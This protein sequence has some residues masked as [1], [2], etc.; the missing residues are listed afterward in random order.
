MRRPE[1][2]PRWHELLAV[3]SPESIRSRFQYLFKAT[4]HEMTTRYCFIDYD[5]EMAIVAELQGPDGQRSLAGV[6]RLASDAD[7]ERAEYAIL[8]ADPWQGKGLGWE[9]TRYCLE[10][11]QRTGLREVYAET[12]VDNHRMLTLFEEHGFELTYEYTAG[13]VTAVKRLVPQ[14]S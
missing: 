6:G 4:T 9:L 13:H 12:T 8:V 1:D 11:A 14:P 5:R 3:S 7:R 10:V 2:E